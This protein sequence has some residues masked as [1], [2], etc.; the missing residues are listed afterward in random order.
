MK[1][2][3]IIRRKILLLGDSITKGVDSN[4]NFGF[5][6]RFGYRKELQDTLGGNYELVGSYTSPH[7]FINFLLWQNKYSV[8]HSGVNGG[9]TKQLLNKILL[10]LQI[11]LPLDAPE[12]NTGLLLAYNSILI[13]IGTND[14][15]QINLNTNNISKSINKSVN[16]IAETIKII[17]NYHK[18]TNIFI[19]LIPPMNNERNIYVEIFNE[20]LKIKLT[21]LKESQRLHKIRIININSELKKNINHY[22]SDDKH[23]SKEGYDLIGRIIGEKILA[24]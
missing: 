14:I 16:N 5:R 23:P 22:L 24:P 17:D 18:E 8:Y 9:N 7:P 4:I 6:N 21:D 12:Y 13:Q 1:K 10:E 11:H 20:L 3:K 15:L 19:S 2:N